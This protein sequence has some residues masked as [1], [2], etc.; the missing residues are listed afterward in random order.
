MFKRQYSGMRVLL[1]SSFLL[2]FICSFSHAQLARLDSLKQEMS[3]LSASK[4]KVDLLLELSFAH[5]QTDIAQCRIYAEEAL[6]ISKRLKDN[7]RTALSHN[8]LGIASELEGNS[9]QAIK[10]WERCIKLSKQSSFLEG[11]MKALNNLGLTHKEKGN[12]EKSLEYFL[13][14]LKIEEAVGNIKQEINTLANIGFLYLSINDEVNAFHYYNLAIK[15]GEKEGVQSYLANPYHRLGEYYVKMEDYQSA[16]SYLKKAYDICDK[17]AQDLRITSVLRLLGQCQFYLDM[18]EQSNRSFIDAEKRLVK[19]GEE[20]TELYTLYHTWAII[21]AE[22]GDYEKA[23]EKANLGYD[24]ATANNL[25]SSKLSSLDLLGQLHEETENFK[26]ALHFQ[27]AAAEQ[28]GLLNLA[29]KAELLVELETKYQLD[30]TNAKLNTRNL[31]T[32]ISVLIAL[33]IALLAFQ[34]YTAN[35]TKQLYNDQ[36]KRQVEKRTKELESSNIKLKN[37]NKELERFAYIA[38]HDLKTPLRN[39]ISFTGLLERRI[40]K[41]KDERIEEYFTFLKSSG[42]RMNSLIEDL[43]EYSK[44]SSAEGMGISEK[45]DLNVLCKELLNTIQ[46]TLLLNNAE[47]HITKRMPTVIANYSSIFLLFK[48]LIENG[49]KYNESDTPSV[50]IDFKSN[51]DGFSILFKDNGIGI[52]EEFYDKIWEMFSRLHNHS[53]YEGT[54]LGLATCQKIMDSLG[55]SIA[56]ESTLGEGSIFT[57]RF[58]KSLLV[59]SSKSQLFENGVSEQLKF[60]KFADN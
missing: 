39:I 45:I 33:L 5:H 21:N 40:G 19:I 8:Y 57:L 53:K 12:I 18:K 34:L 55:G 4:N 24:L 51:E 50:T 23:F 54:G 31:L 60:R 32:Q 6:Q 47:I 46:Q 13:S 26:E 2:F 17:Y 44:F 22:N 48:N 25:E 59:D 9:T 29:K 58:P 35:R 7:N 15:K 30:K 20:F 36:L 42:N 14:A 52:Q 49:I 16:Y 37:S 10:H 38:S 11:E 1:V 41:A 27:K 56:V 28:Y 43:L 3:T